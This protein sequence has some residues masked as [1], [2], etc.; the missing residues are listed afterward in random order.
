MD[1]KL[2]EKA[3]N[4]REAVIEMSGKTIEFTLQDLEG[5]IKRAE[6][7][8]V[9]LEAQAK[10]NR[11][12]MTNIET[13]YPFVLE[14]SEKDLFTCHM[15]QESKALAKVSEMKAEEFKASIETDKASLAEIFEKMPEFKA[16]VEKFDADIKA[17]AEKPA[18]EKAE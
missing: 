11:A 1:Y 9:E 12:K 10:I 13:N 15:Y 5:N 3:E 16:E 2:K 6:K 4:P 18:E 14:M 8:V 17:E 7:T